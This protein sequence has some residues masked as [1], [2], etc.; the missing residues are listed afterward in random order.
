M[1]GESP[2]MVSYAAEIVIQFHLEW[3]SVEKRVFLQT[4]ELIP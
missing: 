1:C 4:T 2:F 3:E